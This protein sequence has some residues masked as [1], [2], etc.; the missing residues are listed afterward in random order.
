VGLVTEGDRFKKR[1]LHDE[2][3]HRRLRGQFLLQTEAEMGE[4]M[5]KKLKQWMKRANKEGRI[6]IPMCLALFSALARMSRIRQVWVL[7]LGMVR[8]RNRRAGQDFPYPWVLA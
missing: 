2:M 7:F 4:E 8:Q 5:E 6:L 1:M 3:T